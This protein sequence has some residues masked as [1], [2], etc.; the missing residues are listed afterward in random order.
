MQNFH[1][2]W[3]RNKDRSRGRTVR[4]LHSGHGFG[5]RLNVIDQSQLEEI[6][7][8]LDRTELAMFLRNGWFPAKQSVIKTNAAIATD[9]DSAHRCRAYG[10]RPS[11]L[12]DRQTVIDAVIDI[13]GRALL[14][15]ST[16]RLSRTRPDMSA[17]RVITGQQAIC[18][19]ILLGALA[20]LGWFEPTALKVLS[21]VTF[22]VLFICV[23]IVKLIS[24][25]EPRPLVLASPVLRDQDL[26]VYTV[27]VPLYQEAVMLKRIFEA[28]NSLDYPRQK[29]DIK[30]IVEQDDT[31][32]R[33]AAMK[34]AEGTD[35]DVITVP[36][37]KPRTKPRALNFAMMF[38]RGSLVTIYDAE[39]IP[40]RSQLRLAANCFAIASPRV[41]C[42]QARLSFYNARE[43]WLTRQFAIEYASLFDLM[44]PMLARYRLP[45]PLGG[46]SNH[47]RMAALRAAGG[48]DAWNVTEDADLGLRLSRLGYQCEV[49]SSS[50]HEEANCQLGNWLHQRARWLKGWMQTWLVHMRSPVRTWR[51]LGAARFMAAQITLMGIIGSALLHPVFLVLLVHD[52]ILSPPDGSNLSQAIQASCATIVFVAGYGTTMFIGI[53]AIVLRRLKNIAP[54]ILSMPVYWLLISIGGWLAVWQLLTA[55]FEWNKTKHGIS[56][57]QSSDVTGPRG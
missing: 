41:A 46:T 40:Q 34:L 30:I 6:I 24:A 11:A 8:R 3:L 33:R 1:H 25:V 12:A 39:D 20:F 5:E 22:S 37:G 29:T 19:L 47:F 57:Y 32:T 42:L 36:A 56:K 53:R 28:L 2:S 55:P 18:L 26:P 51:D 9:A 16:N 4:D 7:A 35:I 48:W 44:L 23:S 49:L 52:F 43:N 21:I 15:Q 10:F 14:K 45:L 38:A 17:D 50:T 13:H 27:L 31:E 54:A